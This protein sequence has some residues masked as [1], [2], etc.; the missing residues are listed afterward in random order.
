M[1]KFIKSVA[2]LIKELFIFIVKLP[3]Y[4]STL[5]RSTRI[6]FDEHNGIVESVES[7]YKIRELQNHNKDSIHYTEKEVLRRLE[8]HAKSLT[9]IL[10][11]FSIWIAVFALIISIL[12]W[13]LR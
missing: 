13:F 12:T 8:E 4:A 6:L 3:F 5:F 2:I 9:K 11:T 10:N 1:N 7:I